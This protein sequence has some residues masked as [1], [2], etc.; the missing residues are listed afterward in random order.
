MG[1]HRAATAAGQAVADLP[2]PGR[3][4]VLGAVAFGVLG[5]VLGLV[6]GLISYPPTAWFA[7]VEVGVPAAVAGAVVGLG[8]GSGRRWLQRDRR[9]SDVR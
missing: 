1:M 5:G 8:V 2:L 9:E 4:A 6:L 3:F 7:V